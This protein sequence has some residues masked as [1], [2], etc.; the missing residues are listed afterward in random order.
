MLVGYREVR[1]VVSG[2]V[3]PKL[4][5][6]IVGQSRDSP[7]LLQGCQVLRGLGGVVTEMFT[8]VD[9]TT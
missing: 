1:G 8:K 5:S 9:T 3:A 7:R 2:I 6:N 4:I